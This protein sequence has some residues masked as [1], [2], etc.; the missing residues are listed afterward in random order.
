MITNMKF[1]EK[2]RP[3]KE[4]KL[5]EEIPLGFEFNPELD[6]ILQELS[7]AYSA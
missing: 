3:K 7:K 1:F 4:E 6:I 2:F 5:K